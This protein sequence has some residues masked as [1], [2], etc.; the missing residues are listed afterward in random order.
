MQNQGC[1]ISHNTL[2]AHMYLPCLQLVDAG[3][4]YA[5]TPESDDWVTCA[6]CDLGLDGWE[7]SDDPM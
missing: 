1:K 6:Y 5:P 4:I 3:W 2:F 7:P